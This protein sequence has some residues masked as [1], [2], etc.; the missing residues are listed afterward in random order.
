V[1]VQLPMMF[2]GSNKPLGCSAVCYAANL[3]NIGAG[4]D[5]TLCGYY[6]GDVMWRGNLLPLLVYG[7]QQQQH[8]LGSCK[9]GQTVCCA[10]CGMPPCSRLVLTEA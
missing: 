8:W 9:C 4:T 2:D 6:W 3:A 10:V 5:A 7:L 1:F